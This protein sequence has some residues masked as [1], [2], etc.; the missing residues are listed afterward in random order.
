MKSGCKK[1]DKYL[2]YIDFFKVN[3]F[4]AEVRK[5]AIKIPYFLHFPKRVTQKSRFIRGDIKNLFI[6]SF[7]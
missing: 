2:K 3:Y 5:K 1:I 6:A 7:F 4:D